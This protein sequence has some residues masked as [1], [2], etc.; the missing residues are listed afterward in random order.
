M[1]WCP[2]GSLHWVCE[3]MEAGNRD[4]EPRICV[5]KYLRLHIYIYKIKN[6]LIS[7][8]HIHLIQKRDIFKFSGA[9]FYYIRLYK[10]SG[11]TESNLQICYT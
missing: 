4:D 11:R 8:V 10:Y 1:T 3:E 5:A 6:K 7:K 2:D 9:N